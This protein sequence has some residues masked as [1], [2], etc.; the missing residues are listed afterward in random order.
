MV[1]GTFRMKTVNVREK[2]ERPDFDA[3]Y[4]QRTV[5]G[6]KTEDYL[7]GDLTEGQPSSSSEPQAL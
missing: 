5:D 2:A 4:C 3:I 1:K 7:I 6:M